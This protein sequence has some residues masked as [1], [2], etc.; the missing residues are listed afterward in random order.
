M[1]IIRV[2]PG[3]KATGY[4][5]LSWIDGRIRLLETGTIEP[6]AKD[7]VQNR[8]HK[9]YSL[10]DETLQ[11]HQPDVLVLEK[12]YSHAKY[13]TTSSL[14]GHVRGVICLLSAQRNIELAEHSPKRIRK[15]IT[16]NG[17]STKVQTRKVVA[18]IL[19]INAAQSTLDASDALAMALGYI[20]MTSRKV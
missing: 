20:Y 3:M 6:K 9:V 10:L 11:E 1:T 19:K 13:P 15:A 12:L 4:G 18:D 17:N 8:I 14:L 16:G 7:L 5:C 2:D